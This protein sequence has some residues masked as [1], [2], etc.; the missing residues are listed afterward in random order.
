[1]SKMMIEDH[2]NGALNAYNTDNG[3]CFDILLK[4]TFK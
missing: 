2:M 4:K 1:M 3:V